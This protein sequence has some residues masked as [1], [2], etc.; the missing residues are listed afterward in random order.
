VAK[1]KYLGRMVTNQN[2]IQEEIKSRLSSGNAFYY[3]VYSLLSSC[4]L[5]KSLK[6][7]IYITV[8]LPAVSYGCETWSL[9]LTEE[10]RLRVCEN[11]V[12]RR[13]I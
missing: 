3:S 10:H 2:C 1:F 9:T 5:S 13:I 8:I 7:K 4:L 12:E 11:R 6:L